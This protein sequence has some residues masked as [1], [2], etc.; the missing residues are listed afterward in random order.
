MPRAIQ[1]LGILRL[2]FAFDY[3]GIA[4]KKKPKI[5]NQ[6]QV[7]LEPEGLLGLN[8]CPSLLFIE[9]IEWLSIM[10]FLS[11]SQ[12]AQMLPCLRMQQLIRPF[13]KRFER[14]MFLPISMNMKEV[15]NNPVLCWN[16]PYF[17]PTTSWLL[18]AS[19]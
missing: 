14:L 10:K 8:L 15:T 5:G 2:P 19:H 1:G 18:T 6:G 16:T 17:S 4:P 12:V 7:K 3:L 13:F 11:L 9:R